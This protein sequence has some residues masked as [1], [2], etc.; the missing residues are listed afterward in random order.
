MLLSVRNLFASFGFVCFLGLMYVLFSS[1]DSLTDS[2]GAS[3]NSSSTDTEEQTAALDQYITQVYVPGSMTFAGES[4]P[5]HEME[6]RERLDR[7]LTSITYRHSHTIRIMKL[8]Q[9]WMPV[10]EPILAR[11]GLPDDFKYLAIA[12]SGLENATSP[13]GARGFWQFMRTTAQQYGMEVS[14]DVD[15]RYH[16]E[17]ATEAACKYL[18]KSKERFGT[19]SMACAAYNRGSSGMA[20]H[21]QDQKQSDYYNLYLNQET[22]RYMFRILAYK[23]LME[24]PHLYGFQLQPHDL[25]PPIN[26]RTV[27]VN[28]IGDIA[29]FA[30]QHNTTYKYIKLLNPW[31]RTQ[32]L[33]AR[34]GKQYVLKVP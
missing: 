20:D 34:S 5:L 31:L 7:E 22:Y 15:E 21:V 16:V 12:E 24:N 32:S 29:T 8:A 11:H 26:Y 30:Q 10:I 14:T 9:R 25:Y 4:V 28:S 33:R 3:T 18:H 19:W 27:T 17:K 13:A 6:I 23:Q 2:L 1:S